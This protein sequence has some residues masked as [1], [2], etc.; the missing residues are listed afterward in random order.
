MKNIILI[1]VSSL[2]LLTFFGSIV[3]KRS[4]KNKL[5][6]RILADNHDYTFNAK[7]IVNSISK[8]KDL[9]KE[10]ITSIHPDKFIGIEKKQEAT[11]LASRVTKSK[12]NYNDLLNLKIEIIEFLKN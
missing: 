8:S 4:K 5:K 6:Q 9:Y 1:A 3:K 11:K 12:K 2:V 10:L 7:N